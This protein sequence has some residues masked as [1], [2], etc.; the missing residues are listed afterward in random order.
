MVFD[1]TLIIQALLKGIRVNFS[2]KILSSPDPTY[3]LLELIQ[4]LV[5]TWV[6]SG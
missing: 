5:I 2:L 1:L 4:D 6:Y 3:H